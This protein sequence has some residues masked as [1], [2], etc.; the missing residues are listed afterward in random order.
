MRKAAARRS[1]AIR[2][3]PALREAAAG[4][5]F[6][7]P[8]LFSLF[9]FTAYPVLASLFFSFTEYN[10]L[11][12][13]RWVGIDNYTRM[14]TNDASYLIGIENSAYYALI[15]VPVG[16]VFS[17]AIAVLLNM[18]VKGMG[19]YRTLI[20]LPSLAP[21][22]AGAMIFMLLF[23][24]GGGLVN[25]V[26]RAL[27]L[28][29]PGWFLDAHWS[30]PTLIVMNLWGIGS[31]ALIFLAGLKEVPRTLLEAAEI[32]GADTW[33]RFWSITIPFISPIILFNLV[34][35]VIGSFQVFTSAF[36]V[37]GTRGEPLESTLFYMTVIYRNAFRY[38]AMGYASAAA[39]VLFLAILIVTMIIFW[40]SGRWVYYEGAVRGG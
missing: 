19:A 27:G 32:D 33:R 7:L 22:V 29:T 21:P 3:S 35:G 28:P 31:S 1:R 26:L 8:W 17:L 4:Y 24:P 12:P 14:F 11:Q 39:I 6:V 25:T 34:M 37:G 2:L 23:N 16:L 38:F 40:T 20:Y 5:L 13:P 9:V 10:V 30:K 15:S 36:I 18:N